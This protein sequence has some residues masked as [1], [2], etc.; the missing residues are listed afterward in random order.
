MKKE[1]LALILLLVVLVGTPAGVLGYESYLRSQ[2]PNEFTIVGENGRWKP[3]II[4]V[5]QGDKVVLRLTSG[6]VVHGLALPAFGVMED[7]I[8]PGKFT[9]VEFVADKVGTF[10]FFCTV[11]CSPRHAQMKGELIVEG[12]TITAPSPTP[13]PTPTP[14]I[15]PTP[16]D[17]VAV[18]KALYI[19]NGCSACHGLNAEGTGVAPGIKGLTREAIKNK[20]RD[21]KSQMMPAYPPETISETDLDKIVTFLLSLKP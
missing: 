19:A 7:D 5:N 14:T 1:I 17:V 10:P 6:D 16:A 4:R 20:V 13:T 15:T 3:D 11:I 12:V 18:G 9:T 2:T 8:Y 21:P